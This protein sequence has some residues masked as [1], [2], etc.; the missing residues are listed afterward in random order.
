MQNDQKCIKR[1]PWRRGVGRALRL[2]MAGGGGGQQ[3]KARLGPSFGFAFPLG[4]CQVFS[5]VP[6]RMLG[7]RGA[8]Q[9]KQAQRAQ[10][11]IKTWKTWNTKCVRTT[12]LAAHGHAPEARSQTPSKEAAG[13]HEGRTWA[14]QKE[15]NSAWHEE[16]SLAYH[17]PRSQAR[18]C[19]ASMQQ[20]GL[21]SPRQNPNLFLSEL[22]ISSS[23]SFS[24]GFSFF[25]L[26]ALPAMLESRE[27]LFV[28]DC[29]RL[30]LG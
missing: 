22:Q 11:E 6:F 7:R 29:D 1:P 30:D 15:T 27:D 23:V 26:P 2:P 14:K 4:F 28:A 18:N 9:A 17:V 13:L 25:I 21:H 12:G 8:A 10:Q 19:S 16:A 24:C 5:E 3:A 20:V